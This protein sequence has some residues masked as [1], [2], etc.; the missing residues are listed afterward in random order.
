MPKRKPTQLYLFPELN[1]TRKKPSPK[2][3]LSSE[4]I[5]SRLK[6]LHTKFSSP[7]E[8]KESNLSKPR[9]LPLFPSHSHLPTTPSIKAHWKKISEMETLFSQ[10]SNPQT[11]KSLSSQNFLNKTYPFLFQVFH[12]FTSHPSQP[13]TRLILDFEKYLRNKNPSSFSSLKST[14][15]SCFNYKNKKRK[16]PPSKKELLNSLS[17]AISI[18]K[19]YLSPDFRS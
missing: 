14:I 18:Y 3:T 8:P 10:L 11:F 9:Q 4:Q 13:K 6:K 12:L 19:L 1:P 15:F 7:S 17:S 2:K 5:E 16:T